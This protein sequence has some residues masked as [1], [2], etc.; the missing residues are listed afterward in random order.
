MLSQLTPLRIGLI[1]GTLM[2]LHALALYYNKTSIDSPYQYISFILYVAGIFFAVL[3]YSLSP[4]CTGKFGDMFS[5]GFRAFIVITLVM[6]VFTGIFSTLHPEIAEESG[7][8]YRVDLIAKKEKTPAEIDTE[9]A[10]FKKQYTVQSIS[11]SI[12]GYLLLGTAA[13]ALFTVILNKRK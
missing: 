5:Q 3:Q 6:V 8:K 2:L 11:V 9:V 4:Q 13:T 10:T 7:E 12:F 1:T